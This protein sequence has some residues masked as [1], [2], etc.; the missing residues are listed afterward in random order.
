VRWKL[1]SRLLC[2][3][4]F[5]CCFDRDD[6]KHSGRL[7]IRSRLEIWQVVDNGFDIEILD[8]EMLRGDDS[9]RLLGGYRDAGSRAG[10]DFG[11][12]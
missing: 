2:N 11:G 9:V 4:R 6:S 7:Y 10:E 12:N 5:G 8:P 1:L 3:R